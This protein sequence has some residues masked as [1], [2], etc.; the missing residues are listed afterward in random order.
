[1]PQ[2]FFP[3]Y[4]NSSIAKIPIKIPSNKEDIGPYEKSFVIKPYAE[5]VNTNNRIRIL[6]IFNII[7]FLQTVR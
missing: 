2:L 6:M 7:S 5:I 3:L 1:M 4:L